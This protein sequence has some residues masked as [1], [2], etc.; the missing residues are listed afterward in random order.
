M[1]YKV[2]MDIYLLERS[3]DLIEEE[4]DNNVTYMDNKPVR[5]YTR[6]LLLLSV[7]IDAASRFTKRVENIDPSDQESV[8][9]LS[10]LNKR[11]ARIQEIQ[12]TVNSELGSR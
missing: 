1:V 4:F 7:Y 8:D 9:C 12:K 5:N 3:A 10:Y 11:I 2:D 6:L